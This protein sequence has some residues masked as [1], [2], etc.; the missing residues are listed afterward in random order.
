MTPDGPARVGIGGLEVRT[1]GALSATGVGSCVVL[2]LHD[3]VAKIAGLAHPMLPERANAE[4]S[5]WKYVDGALDHLV[6]RMVAAGAMKERLVARVAGGASMFKSAW[7]DKAR[8]VGERNVEAARTHLARH[9]IAVA[10][11]DVGGTHGRTVM[12]QVESGAM[13]V[14]GFEGTRTI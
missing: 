4:E 2:A 14:K 3:P 8:T 6:A 11:E 13:L 9:G 7:P 10:G 1:S 5:A 12:V